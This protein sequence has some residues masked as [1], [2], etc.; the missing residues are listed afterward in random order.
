MRAEAVLACVAFTLLYEEWL[1][2]PNR[3]CFADAI[4][5]ARELLNGAIERLG[6]GH[7]S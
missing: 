2:D 7:L 5:V 3:P 6:S 1:E 4:A